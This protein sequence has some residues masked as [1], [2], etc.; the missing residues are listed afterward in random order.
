ML[1]LIVEK[2]SLKKIKVA[3]VLNNIVPCEI[4]GL[5]VEMIGDGCSGYILTNATCRLAV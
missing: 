2:K 4:A 3:N 5:W 1:G